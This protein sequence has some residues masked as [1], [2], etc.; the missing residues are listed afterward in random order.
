MRD[1][2]P[3][4]SRPSCE[5]AIKRL[6]GKVSLKVS[7]VLAGAPAGLGMVKV[8][9]AVCPTPTV[10]GAKAL[11]SAGKLCTVSPEL[12]TPLGTRAV[13][14]ILALVLLYGPPTMLDGTS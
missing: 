5:L 9:V 6:A 3:L 10:V 14:L 4:P 8:S 2:P 12:V 13:A 1:L 7:P 11:G